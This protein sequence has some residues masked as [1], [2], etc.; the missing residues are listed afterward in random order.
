ASV[1][2]PETFPGP[3]VLLDDDP[4]Y[5]PQSFRSWKRDKDRNEVT[6]ARGVIYVAPPPEVKEEVGFV[7]GWTRPVGTGGQ[8]Q[9][10]TTPHPEMNDVVDYLAAF[11]HPVPIKLL[12]AST[13]TFSAWIE[14]S[15]AKSRSKHTS[16]NPRYIALNTPTESIRIRT[17]LAPSSSTDSGPGPLFPDPLNLDD[18]LDAALSIL[19]SDAYAI[20]CLVAHDIYESEDDD[21]ACGRAYGASRIAVV[22]MAR[23][24]PGLDGAQGLNEI[25][26]W[27]ASH[28]GEHGTIDAAP[29]PATK[30]RK[31]ATTSQPSQQALTPLRAA[32]AHHT[33][34]PHPSSVYL[35]RICRT[36]SHELG[37]CFGM[38]HCVYYACSMQ[39]TTS[40]AEDMRQPPY[41]CPVDLGKVITATS[42]GAQSVERIEA[43]R[44]RERYG[45]MIRVCQRF[46]GRFRQGDEESRGPW[47]AF[48]AWI[49]GRVQE[50]DN[51]DDD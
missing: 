13:L 29:P 36:A 32:F 6:E 37:H 14:D 1:P 48:G 34:T 8:A 51:E 45:A 15:K 26:P 18:L 39:G 50:L 10:N 30:K 49:E 41:L 47:K 17:R 33:P 11:Y 9:Y 25:R 42:A 35:F 31:S 28:F 7:T 12:P 21:I 27:P 22:S 19:P 43:E 16:Q 3:V 4:R 2:S 46:A 23:Y 20:L 5:P 44:I 24:D 40:L 38:D